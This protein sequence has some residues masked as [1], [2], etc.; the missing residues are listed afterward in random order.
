LPTATR[1]S[2]TPPVASP[3]A[4]QFL[5][6]PDGEKA[7][8]KVHYEAHEEV[9]KEKMFDGRKTSALLPRSGSG[10]PDF[11]IHSLK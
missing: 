6:D 5:H 4:L 11:H 3:T 9:I 2:K 8:E 10:L 1:S 7:R